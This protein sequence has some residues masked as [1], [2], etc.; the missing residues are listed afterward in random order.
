MT[1]LE[2]EGTQPGA[3]RPPTLEERV[4]RLEGRVEFI[5]ARV[6]HLFIKFIVASGVVE[7]AK[8]FIIGS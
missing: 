4:A 1:T 3:Q 8:L 6:E 5:A 7:L 2:L